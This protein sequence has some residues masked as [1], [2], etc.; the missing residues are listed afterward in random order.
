MFLFMKWSKFYSYK[1]HETS[2]FANQT[3][4]PISSKVWTVHN[5]ICQSGF[6]QT[7]AY[8]SVKAFVNLF[9]RSDSWQTFIVTRIVVKSS[10]QS[11]GEEILA[12][13]R[14]KRNMSFF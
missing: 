13:S 8:M 9:A 4:G 7:K 10:W 6:T 11:G 12:S 2:E 5:I 3:R 14:H 1:L